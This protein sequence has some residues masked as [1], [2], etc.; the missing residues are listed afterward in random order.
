MMFIERLWVRFR[1][2]EGHLGVKGDAVVV[3]FGPGA[4]GLAFT[5]GVRGAADPGVVGAGEEVR[6]WGCG[7]EVGGWGC[8]GGDSGGEE[9]EEEG[10]EEGD[11]LHL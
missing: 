8:V 4:E 11:D 10:E 3:E 5:F 2:A 7:R 1:S 6:C 9:G